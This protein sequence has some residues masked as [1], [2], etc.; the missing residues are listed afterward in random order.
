[1]NKYIVIAFILIVLL[2]FFLII[3]CYVGIKIASEV[4]QSFG[5]GFGALLAGL[6]GLTVFWDWW[7][8]K[9][10]K[11]NSIEEYKN[12]YP[13][14][15]LNKTFKIIRYKN[16][17]VRVYILD[18]KDKTRHWV[19]DPP[20]LRALGFSGRDAQTLEDSEF[21]GHKEGEEI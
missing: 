13:R 9:R 5:V 3:P 12:I 16:D 8:K 15:N 21:E 4:F 14:F 11:D 7:Q 6:G 19:K 1:M 20:T 10:K 2:I 18:L 17:N